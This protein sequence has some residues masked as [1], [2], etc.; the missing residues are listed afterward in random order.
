MEKM[1]VFWPWSSL[2]M[3]ACTVPRTFSSTW[4]EVGVLP[5]VRQAALGRLESIDLL[6]DGRVEKH[7]QHD[8]GRPVDGHGNRC[9]GCTQIEAAVKH[10]SHRR[11]C[12]R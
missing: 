11:G 3:S 8:G 6:I 10:S 2:R 4:P 9:G 7:G 5:I 1:Q 12:R